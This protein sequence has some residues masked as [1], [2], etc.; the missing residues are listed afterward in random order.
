VF[1]VLQP[2][3]LSRLTSP[4]PDR[5]DAEDNTVICTL[6]YVM[7]LT[8]KAVSCSHYRI[9][10]MPTTGHGRRPVMCNHGW[11]GGV[12]GRALKSY[13][14]VRK[15]LLGHTGL[16]RGVGSL[17]GLVC[18]TSDVCGCS[19]HYRSDLPCL[20]RA[21]GRCCVL[22]Y[23]HATLTHRSPSGYG[24][25]PRGPGGSLLCQGATS[26]GVRVHG[27]GRLPATHYRL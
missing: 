3:G 19:T 11:R 9:S 15:N 13:K 25:A 8:R 10:S 27:A 12:A 14:K 7:M 4:A 16:C 1:W 20:R 26:K 2:C 17:H 18:L 6:I 22:P 5:L 21:V 23:T 24:S